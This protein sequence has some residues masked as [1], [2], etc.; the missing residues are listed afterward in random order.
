M[1]VISVKQGEIIK[2]NDALSVIS[3]EQE[4]IIKRP[5]FLE[6]KCSDPIYSLSYMDNHNMLQLGEKLHLIHIAGI[7]FI[8][9]FVKNSLKKLDLESFCFRSP[10]III[11]FMYDI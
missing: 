10:K 6:S 11:F 4:E 2:V 9:I 1:S 8:A 5:V 7:C 3:V